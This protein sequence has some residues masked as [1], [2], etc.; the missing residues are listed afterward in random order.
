M[1]FFLFFSRNGN[2]YYQDQLNTYMKNGISL[3]TKENM[4]VNLKGFII[5]RKLE[6]PYCPQSTI[7]NNHWKFVKN[8]KECFW[9]CT[10]KLLLFY[11]VK[12]YINSELYYP[13]NSV[14]KITMKIVNFTVQCRKTRARRLKKVQPK[15]IHETLTKFF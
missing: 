15:K 4:I 14:Q 11:Y 3:Y 12:N 7:I 1:I 6:K 5:Q 9:I 13:R 2:S 8:N 10:R